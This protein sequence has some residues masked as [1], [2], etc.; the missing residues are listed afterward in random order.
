M[1]SDWEQLEAALDKAIASAVERTDAALA[2]RVSALTRLTEA[3]VRSL[4]PT[5][6]DVRRLQRLMDIV[7]QS[8]SDHAAI[9]RLET[10]ITDLAGTVVRLLGK[11]I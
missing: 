8:R 1:R 3:E 9:T 11:V 5:P 4:F 6:A 2:S 10:S 7:E